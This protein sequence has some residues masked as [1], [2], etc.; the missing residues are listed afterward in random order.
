MYTITVINTNSL[1]ISIP[2]QFALSHANALTSNRNE[3]M[4]VS[5]HIQIYTKDKEECEDIRMSVGD[6]EFTIRITCPLS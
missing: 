2:F 6:M 5:K 4:N 3:M 1:L